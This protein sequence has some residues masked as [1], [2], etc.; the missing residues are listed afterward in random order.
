MSHTYVNNLIHVV[1][2]TKGRRPLLTADICGDLYP[3]LGGIAREAGAKTLA[4]GGTT[5]HV[6]ALLLLPAT[7]TLARAIQMLK[8]SSSR[9]LH[10]RFPQQADFEW[11]Q[12]YGA[13]SVSNSL[14]ERTV[15]YIHRQ[16]EHHRKRTFEDELR[17]ILETQGISYDERY[18]LG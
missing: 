13:F 2:S 9:W 6:H 1:F 11:Q 18:L 16:A 10:E 5:D 14:V 17:A 8:G 15:S 4:V 12:G 7:L 3:Y